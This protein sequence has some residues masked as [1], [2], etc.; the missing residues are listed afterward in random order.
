MP[1][2]P[3]AQANRQ[4]PAAST[5]QLVDLAVER[6]RVE[7]ARGVLAERRQVSDLEALLAL[8]EQLAVRRSEA[9]DLAGAEVAV[10]VA[11]TGRGHGRAAVDVAAGHGAASA[12][13]LVGHDREDEPADGIRALPG[14][15]ARLPL[16][17]AP[18]VVVQGALL[19]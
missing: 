15:E 8:A 4:S 14:L 19:L 3:R 10:E 11:A 5:G 18:A 17:D 6:R 9:P 13:V 7:L 12:V 2:R 1:R 16:P